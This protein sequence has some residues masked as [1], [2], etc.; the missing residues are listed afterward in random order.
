MNRNLFFIAAA[1]LLW[2]FGEGMFFNFVPIR[3][4]NDFHLS[5]QSVGLALGAFGFFMAITHLPGG[6]L[7]DRV[8][9]RPL[10]ITAW[11]FGVV[12]TLTM[13]LADSLPAYLMGLFGYGMTAF[14]ASPLGSYVTAARGRLP[15]GAALSLTTATFNIGMAL[16]PVT[17]GW[18]AEHYGMRTSYLA[19]FGLFV[20]STLFILAI[21]SQSLDRH[22]PDAP[23][24]SLWRNARFI[25]FVAVFAFAV[26]ATYLSQPLTPNFLKGARGLTLTETGWVFSAGALGNSLLSLGIGRFLHPRRGFILA[27]ALVAF[28]ATLI[29]RGAG[30]STFMLAYFLLGG[31]RAARPMAMAQARELVHDSQMGISYGAMETVSAAIF[32]VAPPIAGFIFERDPYFIYPLAIGLIVVSIFVS[33]FFSPRAAKSVIGD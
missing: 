6:H 28:F 4:E 12:S 16:G 13:W 18:I 27:Q 1:L 3:L 19:A 17:G 15:I 9:R 24:I 21:E 5:K 26:F 7:S 10:L 14:V 8:G 33:Y 20:V 2:G 29:W 32:I 31:F 23:P 25:N 22:D 30:L 11:L